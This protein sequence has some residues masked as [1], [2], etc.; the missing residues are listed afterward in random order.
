M[1]QGST[2]PWVDR[3]HV[4]VLKV[5]MPLKSEDTFFKP[6]YLTLLQKRRVLKHYSFLQLR[7]QCLLI[8]GPA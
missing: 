8:L 5:N 1:S 7:S 4:S 6:Y 3:Y 2:F